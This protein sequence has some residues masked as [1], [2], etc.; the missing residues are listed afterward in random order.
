MIV[1]RSG[2]TFVCLPLI[3]YPTVN[4]EKIK[5]Y[6]FKLLPFELEYLGEIFKFPELISVSLVRGEFFRES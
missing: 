3:K 2:N 4:I 6:N 1:T 5:I